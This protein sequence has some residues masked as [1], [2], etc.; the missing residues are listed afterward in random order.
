[1]KTLNLLFLLGFIFLSLQTA[2][3]LQPADST[4]QPFN[5]MLFLPAVLSQLQINKSTEQ[6][7]IQILGKPL[8][9]EK[10]SYFYNLSGRNYDTTIGFKQG[11]I[12]YILY[13]PPNN[14]LFLKDL[15]NYIPED[16]LNKALSQAEKD[17]LNPEKS[18]SPNPSFNI[19]LKNK[20]LTININK[21]SKLSV[22]HFL[23]TKN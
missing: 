9:K 22:E 17:S 6:Q 14:Q 12:A 11:K 2:A 3:S 10:G 19:V 16:I 4:E 20:G 23:I 13:S 5:V 1:M 15:R 8:K 7:L 18:H 21:N